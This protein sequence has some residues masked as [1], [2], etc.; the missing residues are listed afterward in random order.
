MQYLKEL[1]NGNRVAVSQEQ[2]NTDKLGPDRGNLVYLVR[3]STACIYHTNG[4]GYRPYVPNT[5]KFGG[6]AKRNAIGFY[7]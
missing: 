7:S 6:R 4:T 3:T 2:Y 1:A 5:P